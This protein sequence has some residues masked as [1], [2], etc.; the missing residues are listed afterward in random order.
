MPKPGDEKEVY[1]FV[2]GSSVTIHKLGYVKSDLNGVGMLLS[3]AAV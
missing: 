1:K 2:D 3:L